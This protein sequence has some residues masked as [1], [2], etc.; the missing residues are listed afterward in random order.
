[1]VGEDNKDHVLFPRKIGGH[2]V[3]LHRR[4]PQVWLAYSADLRTWDATE[5]API[6]GPR[7]DNWW[8]AT[9]VGNNG[10]PISRPPMARFC[11]NHGYTVEMQ[12]GPIACN[13]R[14]A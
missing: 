4:W 12:A 14:Q 10:A 11:L 3:A 7:P 1:M 8:D 2:Y 5:M 13:R 6:Y 9:S